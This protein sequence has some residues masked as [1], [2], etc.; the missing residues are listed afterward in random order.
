VIFVDTGAFL[1][2]YLGH[3]QYHPQAIQIWDEIRRRREACYTTNCV[4]NEVIT[5]LGRRA[6]HHFTA[7]RALSIY[8]SK[9][10]KIMR[11]DT[12]IERQAID[13]FEKYGDQ[14]VSFTD[15]ISFVL[16]KNAG[17]KRAFSFDFHFRLAGYT[18]IP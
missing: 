1:A 16:M 17:I 15:C 3:D 8:A 11:P 10:I 12:K 6:G 9:V 2:R 4:L 5:L 13:I 18:V 7:E 14:K